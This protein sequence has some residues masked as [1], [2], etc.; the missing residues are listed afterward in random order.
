MAAVLGFKGL[1]VCTYDFGRLLICAE[2]ARLALTCGLTTADLL[3]CGCGDIQ[4]AAMRPLRDML[5][6]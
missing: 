6:I 1:S 3:K 4:G 2:E 5:K